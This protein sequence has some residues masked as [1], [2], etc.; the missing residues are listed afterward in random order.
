L[1]FD[2]AI[3]AIIIDTPLFYYAI[4]FSD[5]VIDYAIYAITLA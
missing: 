5:A 4:S 2:I 1:F 3:D